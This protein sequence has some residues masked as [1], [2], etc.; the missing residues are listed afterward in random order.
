ME[1]SSVVH[2][3]V[4]RTTAHAEYI[5]GEE[6]EKRCTAAPDNLEGLLYDGEVA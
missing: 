4:R 3:S 5:N 6:R 1:M 2:G